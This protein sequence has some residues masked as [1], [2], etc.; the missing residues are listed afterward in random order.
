MLREQRAQKFIIIAIASPSS[1]ASEALLAEIEVNGRY[2]D[3]SRRIKTRKVKSWLSRKSRRGKQRGY[4]TPI[5]AVYRRNR[6][7]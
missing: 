4:S 6:K 5:D 1:S 2:V 7:V 3:I